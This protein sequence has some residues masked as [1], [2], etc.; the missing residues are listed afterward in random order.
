MLVSAQLQPRGRAEGER[1]AQ[2]SPDSSTWTV[3]D[4]RPYSINGLEISTFLRCLV[5]VCA[6]ETVSV[7]W[8]L[9][10]FVTAVSSI[11]YFIKTGH[12]SR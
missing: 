3:L 2:V 5:A 9:C 10:L 6:L 11:S 1:R 8:A 4:Y 7:M 12:G